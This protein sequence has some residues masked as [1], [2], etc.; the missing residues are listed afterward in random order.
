MGLEQVDVRPEVKYHRKCVIL[1]ECRDLL[2]ILSQLKHH[3]WLVG[4]V[5]QTLNEELA[6]RV[7]EI[8]D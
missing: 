2:V 4:L 6:K 8:T 1:K 3:F 7:F 5:G